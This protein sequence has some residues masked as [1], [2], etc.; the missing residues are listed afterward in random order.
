MRVGTSS[1]TVR[2]ADRGSSTI[3]FSRFGD[4]RLSVMNGMS[5]WSIRAKPWWVVSFESNT[6]C[7][8][9]FPCVRFQKVMKRKTS[10]GSSPFRKSAFE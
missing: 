1:S 8:G 4:R 5:I 6:R 3:S 10:S 9:S 7:A 2:Q